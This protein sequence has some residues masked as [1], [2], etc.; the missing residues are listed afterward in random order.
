MPARVLRG[1]LL[2]ATTGCGW[3]GGPSEPRAPSEV[4]ERAA[5]QDEAVQGASDGAG[6]HLAD[7]PTP[8]RPE[9]GRASHHGIVEREGERTV[10]GTC[11][12]ERLVLLDGQEQ[13]WTL[14]GQAPAW[15]GLDVVRVAATT[16]ERVD[17]L[18]GAAKVQEVLISRP[19]RAGDCDLDLSTFTWPPQEP[20]SV[21]VRVDDRRGVRLFGTLP[22]GWSPPDGLSTDEAL[23]RELAA[24]SYAYCQQELGV[25]RVTW[26]VEDDQG[27]VV[28]SWFLPCAIADRLM[29]RGGAGP[30]REWRMT[31]D[32]EDLEMSGPE[33]GLATASRLLAFR[34][35]AGELPVRCLEDGRCPEGR[36]AAPA[37]GR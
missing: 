6:R 14:E 25:H 32:G 3:W 37:K 18:D 28:G 5:Q 34:K 12:G 15:V 1:C 9:L 13:P 2:A 33:V 31:R 22:T 11:E 16:R 20:V 17:G 23:I 10:L 26:D 24:G 36:D 19:F 4:A 8:P 7:A 27:G 21:K 30:D 35:L 29:A